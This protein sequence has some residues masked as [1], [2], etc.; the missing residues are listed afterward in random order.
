MNFHAC[1]NLAFGV[2]LTDMKLNT[3]PHWLPKPVDVKI[4]DCPT[5]TG[6]GFC[7]IKSVDFYEYL[8]EQDDEELAR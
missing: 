3:R 2:S 4:V 6:T 1:T 8:D 7:T 5:P